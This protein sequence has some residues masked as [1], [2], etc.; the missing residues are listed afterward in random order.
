MRIVC[1][2]DT[3]ELHHELIVPPGEI[4][5]HAGDICHMS[6]A[7]KL[8]EFNAWLGSLPH[9]HKIIVPGNHD[10][11]LAEQP[12]LRNLITNASLLINES[13]RVE[14]L[15]IWG[16]PVTCD[17]TAFGFDG[18][19]KR[20]DALPVHTEGHGHHRHPRAPTGNSRP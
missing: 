16:S 2:S 7:R 3:H 5:I 10:R 11:I 4:L 9:R 20:L 18:T 13:I 14:G 1:I 8:S 19:L 12:D 6:S 17:D 15:N